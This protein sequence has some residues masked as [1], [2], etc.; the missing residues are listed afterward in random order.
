MLH[1]LDRIQC[2]RTG[3]KVDSP[4]NFNQWVM[5]LTWHHLNLTSVQSLVSLY[6]KWLFYWM[7]QILIMTTKWKE[8]A[9]AWI[10][11]LIKCLWNWQLIKSETEWQYGLTSFT[12]FTTLKNKD[13]IQSAALCDRKKWTMYRMKILNPHPFR[14]FAGKISCHAGSQTNDQC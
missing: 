13:K 4:P 7:L 11:S 2:F 1:G 10:Q 5:S 3:F 8:N 6:C 9:Y 14:G 12:C